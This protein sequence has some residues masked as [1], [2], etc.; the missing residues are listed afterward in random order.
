MAELSLMG[1]RVVDRVA[2][3]GSF[4]A[5]ADTLGYTQSAVSR[6]VAA[7]E[8]A[9]GAVLFERH[10][11]GVQP[12]PVGQV[13]L[14]H[15]AVLLAAADAAQRELAAAREQLVGRLVVGGYPTGHVVL[16][17]RALA[18]MRDEHPA[19]EVAVHSGGSQSLLRMLR[20]RQVELVVVAQMPGIEHDFTGLR[21]ELLLSGRLRVAVP[22]G[23]R[24]A[25]LASVTPDDL[26][27]E[28]WIVGTGPAG[29][30]HL[31]A[32]PGI[33]QPRIAYAAADWH[34][35]LG[36]VAAGLGIALV[37][38]SVASLISRGMTVVPVDDD[39]PHTRHVFAVT[40]RSANPLA[41]VFVD[42]L[43]QVATSSAL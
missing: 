18:L 1:L 10:A 23:H 38:D 35:R 25:G 36:L 24:L 32:W 11:R 40:Q 9:V 16:L 42:A 28:P 20:A 37:P 15:A 17:P 2:A 31:G 5:A 21:S 7:M 26:R 13:L 22:D 8:A 19:V 29:D 14:R 41:K 6:Q 39:G 3:L 12:T 30:V 43:R 34:A 33:E 4:T 27:E